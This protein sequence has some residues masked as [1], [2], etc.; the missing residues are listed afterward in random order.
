MRD[1]FQRRNTLLSKLGQYSDFLR[2]SV[3]SVCAKCN[4]A[5]CICEKRTLRKAYRLTYKDSQQKTRIVYIPR[6]R[7]P[8]IR[9]MLANYARLRKTMEQLFETNIEIFKR[10]TGS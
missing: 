5:H 9:R 10:G 1:P 6:S 4:R 8:E 3:N 2:G 7:L